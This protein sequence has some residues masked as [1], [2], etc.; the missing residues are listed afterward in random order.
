MEKEAKCL[1]CGA[2]LEGAV[3]CPVCGFEHH[4]W[5]VEPAQALK[6]Y[7]AERLAAAKEVWERLQAEKASV[8][9]NK[10]LGFLITENLVVYCLYEGKN[11]FGSSKVSDNDL[12]QKLI[13][14]GYGLRPVHLSVTVSRGERVNTFTVR[15]VNPGDDPS[16]FVNSRTEPVT[17]GSQLTDGDNLLISIG[18]M[19]TGLKFRVNLNSK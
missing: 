16:V 19:T 9:R 2:D 13:L 1:V 11:T 10:P 5:L 17:D 8:T 18:A 3:L 4:E 14:S 6:E 12:H 7:E 15:E